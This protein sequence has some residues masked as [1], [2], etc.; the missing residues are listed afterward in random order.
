MA[1]EEEKDLGRDD[2]GCDRWQDDDKRMGKENNIL[3]FY[4]RMTPGPEQAP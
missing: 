1:L 3:Y 4:K 2:D